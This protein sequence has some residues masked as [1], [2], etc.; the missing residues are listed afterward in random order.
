MAS[1]EYQGDG[2]AAPGQ[3]DE[4]FHPRVS[5]SEE[6]YTDV[7]GSEIDEEVFLV[8]LN[9]NAFD[10]PPLFMELHDDAFPLF[11]ERNRRLFSWNSD[12][13][14]EAY[15]HKFNRDSLRPSLP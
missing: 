3:G 8:E 13:C 2:G 14:G 15:S 7:T 9:V 5:D 1:Q 10:D 11:E 4:D 6:D 12:F